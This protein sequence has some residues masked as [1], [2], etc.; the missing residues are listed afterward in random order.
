MEEDKIGRIFTAKRKYP[1]SAKG[2]KI[3]IKRGYKVFISGYID[4]KIYLVNT[5]TPPH[6]ALVTKQEFD[7]IMG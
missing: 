4:N 3:R 6:Y 7:R 5:M 2:R 1:F